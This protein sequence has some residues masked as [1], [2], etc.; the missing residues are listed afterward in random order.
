MSSEQIPFTITILLYVGHGK[1]FRAS[2][3]LPTVTDSINVVFIFKLY[4]PKKKL[5][6]ILKIIFYIFYAIK[7]QNVSFHL[8]V[9]TSKW[10][11]KF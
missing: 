11:Y 5:T 6:R 8:C 4:L 3:Q 9:S 10:R 7:E 2:I 1:K